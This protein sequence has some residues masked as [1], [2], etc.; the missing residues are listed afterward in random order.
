MAAIDLNTIRLDFISV[1]KP[2]L[3]LG[4]PFIKAE[5][6]TPRPTNRPYL[7]FK[8]LPPQQIGQVDQAK[9]D[10]LAGN[11]TNESV[12]QIDIVIN[13]YGEGSHNELIALRF[14]F[15]KDSV[16][17]S[18]LSYNMAFRDIT[19]MTDTTSLLD[20]KWEERGSFV[21]SFY[22]LH[23]ENDTVGAIET[24]NAEG[25]VVDPENNIVLNET[26][27]IS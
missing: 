21:V 15:N 11:E 25:T 17:D 3:S 4:V 26:F 10:P 14:Q 16:C 5:Q 12:N 1:V 8:I 20:Q 6:N 27:S 19:E 9:F 7:T 13:G 2:L 24:V 18:L 22:Y 23:S